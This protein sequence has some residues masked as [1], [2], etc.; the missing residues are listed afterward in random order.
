ME[1]ELHSRILLIYLCSDIFNASKDFEV[2]N[3]RLSGE[4]CVKLLINVLNCEIEKTVS[5]NKFEWKK[6]FGGNTLEYDLEK[7]SWNLLFSDHRMWFS[8]EDGSDGHVPKVMLPTKKKRKP[9]QVWEMVKC[10]LCLDLFL[11]NASSL[12]SIAATKYQRLLLVNDE[13]HTMVFNRLQCSNLA[14]T[15]QSN[16]QTSSR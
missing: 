16:L 2:W 1:A 10:A 6:F 5:I 14:C 7:F 3:A 11:Q 9:W 15:P 8:L 12:F 4:R 13:M